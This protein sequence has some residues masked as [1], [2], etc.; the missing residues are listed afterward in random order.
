MTTTAFQTVFD[1]AETI[2][3]NRRAVVAQTVTRD[4]TVRTVSRGGQVWRF[5][6]KLP[7]GLS[8]TDMRP[9]IEAMDK[10]DRFT[11]ALISINQPGL[12]WLNGYQGDA[13]SQTG[14]N[15]TVA[16]G[17]TITLT[18]T[19]A[20]LAPGKFTFKAGDFVQLGAS[21]R[22]YTVVSN[23]VYPNTVVQ[24]N[25]PVFETAGSY[26]LNVGQNCQFQLICTEFPDWKFAQRNIVSW[27]GSFKF[28]ESYV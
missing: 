4:Q 26:A 12:S 20:G 5:E 25:R 1:K 15:A 11:P 21:G 3:I 17:D 16:T 8:W 14:F 24:L 9:I 2:S 23:V 6:V 27:S 10:A 18:S 28:Q 13:T 19:P 22:V 7:D